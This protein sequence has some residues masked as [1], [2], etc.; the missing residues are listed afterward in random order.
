MAVPKRKTSK[1]RKGKRRTHQGLEEPNIPS[2][3][4]VRPS[5]TRSR[6]FF[7]G[8]CNQPKPPHMVCPNCGYYRGKPMLEV[9][10]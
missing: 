9:E 7:C 2:S 10:R 3:Q 1:S 6:R 8:N 4:K 5:G